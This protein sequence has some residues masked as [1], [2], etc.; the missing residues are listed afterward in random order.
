LEAKAPAEGMGDGE[1]G[2][3]YIDTEAGDLYGPKEGSWGEP[4]SLIGP[5]PVGAALLAA[6]VNTFTGESIVI[7]N[8]AG[9]LY[10][11]SSDDE[12]RGGIFSEDGLNF[13][14]RSLVGDLQLD[15]I[16]TGNIDALSNRIKNVAEP[17]SAQDAATKKYV[18]AGVIRGIV[19]SA[20]G[21]SIGVGYT[22]EK[23]ETGKYT[24]TFSTEFGSTPV[25]EVLVS[26]STALIATYAEVTK[27]KLV[28]EIR[29]A[30]GELKD[31]SFAFAVYRV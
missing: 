30:A 27:A 4:L 6:S 16:S 26:G 18:E 22:A 11:S 15:A 29:N 9:G 3:F 13:T 17:T 28:V 8:D 1:E 31:A 19:S 20:G 23:N 12:G 14:V 21:A 24:I 25:P 5:E 2:D 10:I 7:R